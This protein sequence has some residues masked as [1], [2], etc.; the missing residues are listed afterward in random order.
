MR[1]SQ[2]TRTIAITGVAMGM[3]ATLAFSQA[4][5][6]EGFDGGTDGGF[7]GNA[8]FEAA[9]GNPDGN[10]HHGPGGPFFFNELRTGGVAEPVNPNFVGDYSPF[11]DVTFSFD[12]KT[13]SLGDFIGN[14]IVR[15]VG[16]MLVDRDI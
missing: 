8:V 6:I 5:T 2:I 1:F 13:D 14:Q 4:T 12:V 3:F 16:I 15:P 11:D 9:G 10:A 7:T